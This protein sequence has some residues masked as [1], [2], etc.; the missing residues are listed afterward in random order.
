[1]IQFVDKEDAL[2]LR[3]GGRFHNPHNVSI[4]AKLFNENGIV[5]GEDVSVGD[6][7]HIDVVSLF[8]LFSNRVILFLHILAISLDVL[9]HQI[10]PC[11]LVMVRE[12]VQQSTYYKIRYSY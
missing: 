11:Q 4:S 12:V 6:D 10:F 7:I 5:T 9:A 3:L 1:M 8:I 2:S